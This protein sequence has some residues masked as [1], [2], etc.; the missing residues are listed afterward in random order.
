VTNYFNNYPQDAFRL[1]C[2]PH[3]NESMATAL[4]ESQ[5]I[6]NTDTAE[7]TPKPSQE[8]PTTVSPEPAPSR[9]DSTPVP[10][11]QS[12]GGNPD[13]N[14]FRITILL[15]SSGYKTRISV[16]RAF[17]EKASLHEGDGFP[18]G[19]LKSAIWKDWPSGIKA[20][21]TTFT[22]TYLDWP[23]PLP[24]SPNFLRLIYSGRMLADKSTLAG[25]LLS[26]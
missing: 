2:P 23:E 7:A 19:A 18:V 12:S 1:D 20:P 8:Q 25:M 22:D 6:A 13:P 3:S 4:G 9:R 26:R 17:L 5:T 14:A 16:N 11:R 15:A 21:L 10:H 24:P